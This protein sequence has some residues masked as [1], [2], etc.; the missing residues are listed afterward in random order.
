MCEFLTSRNIYIAYNGMY[1]VITMVI[2]ITADRI[3][4]PPLS[5]STGS[6]AMSSPDTRMCEFQMSI[7]MY[8]NIIRILP[9]SPLQMV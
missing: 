4:T 6:V 3:P 7:L 8:H 2:V 9:I 5:N 1:H